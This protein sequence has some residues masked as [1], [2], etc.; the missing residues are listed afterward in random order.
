MSLYSAHRALYTESSC[1][2]SVDADY[3]R[4][5]RR[6]EYVVYAGGVGTTDPNRLLAVSHFGNHLLSIGIPKFA[7]SSMSQRS[8]G[9]LRCAIG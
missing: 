7:S 3:V 4:L 2:T 9:F 1:M 5:R 6:P 8:S